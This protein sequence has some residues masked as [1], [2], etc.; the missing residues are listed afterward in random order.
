MNG[1]ASAPVAAIKFVWMLV[2]V[3]GLALVAGARADVV[4]NPNFPIRGPSNLSPPRIAVTNECST[5]VYVQSFVPGATIKVYLSGSILIGGPIAPP[6]GFGAIPLTRALNAGDV[7]TATQTVNG[8]NSQ[9][10]APMVV[11]RM[12]STLPPPQVGNDIYACGRIV[13]VHGL[14]SGVTVEVR[15]RTTGSVIGN[16]STPNDWGIDWDPVLTSPLNAGHMVDAR[17]FACTGVP[18]SP[19]SAAVP[20]NADPSPLPSP[21]LDPF[22]VGDN[23]LTAHHL[24]TGSF[25]QLFQG[26]VIAQGFSTGETNTAH[27]SPNLIAP[28]P[29]P[30]AQ[31][32]LCTKSPLSPPS[33]VTRL[34]PPK[35]VS[36][37]CGGE[38]AAF[39]TNTTIN[40]ALVLLKNGAIV[41]Y[42]GAAAGLVPVD[43]AP[44]AA[45][46][47][48]DKVQVAEY[49]GGDVA[50][51]NIVIV[52]CQGPG[53]GQCPGGAGC[54]CKPG[55]IC[56]SGLTCVA[57]TCVACG[58]FSQLCCPGN[59]C[60]GSLTCQFSPAQ[61]SYTC[62]P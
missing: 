46:V 21:V 24:L 40:A 55:G 2:A 23:A 42:G 28:P 10:S 52:G 41:G 16:G 47:P 4:I 31:Q 51:S 18:P 29:S 3:A 34:T 1:F 62:L 60:S 44:P 12:P 50:M 53:G 26:S 19:H 30:T 27:V 54:M 25:V 59:V 17:Q 33:E 61:N 9:P 8:V 32:A 56:N 35:L 38:S 58:Q 7:V 57:G 20:V 14:I 48:N 36:P 11:P 43:I 15:D 49:I 13:P 39:V 5:H 45:F 37:I 6:F 22:V